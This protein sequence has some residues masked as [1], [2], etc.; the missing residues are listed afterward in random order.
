M[1]WVEPK[2]VCEIAFE[3]WTR[4]GHIRE[5]SFKGMRADKK[6]KSVV[7]ELPKDEE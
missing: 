1:H 7:I 3:T 5:A 4:A 2:L 6:A